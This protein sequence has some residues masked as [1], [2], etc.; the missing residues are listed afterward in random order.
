MLTLG[1]DCC[2]IEAIIFALK[3]LK[4]NFEH[5]FSCDA[6]AN[7]KK[8]VLA[9][10]NPEIFY[11]NIFGRNIEKMPSVDLYVCGFPCQPFSI[12]GNQ[13]GLKDERN[14]NIFYECFKYIKMKKPKVFIL[15]N[16]K[17][18]LTND[19]GRTITTIKRKL[20]TLKIYNVDYL[21][22]NTMDYGLPQNRERI[23][24]VGIQKSISKRELEA[25]KKVK[26]KLFMDDIID[27]CADMSRPKKHKLTGRESK[28]VTKLRDY[29]ADIDVNINNTPVIMDIGAS[30][31]FA[32]H[33][34]NICPTLKATRANYYIS[35][36]KRKMSVCEALS[37]QGFPKKFKVVVSETSIFK[38]IGNSISVNVLAHLLKEI[39]SS[40]KQ[41][42][43]S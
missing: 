20:E 27:K 40:V 37:V 32:S 7:V 19:N 35:N 39:L 16:V 41:G 25:P 21:L 36:L 11:D 13:L 5:K 43:L 2:G 30:E 4:I 31:R 42:H 26:L 23:F 28:L 12:A 34:V 8:S 18:L 14:G 1:S 10:F 33:R 17:G 6:D 9:N 15:E 3:K 22:L 24:I 29:Y 38:Q